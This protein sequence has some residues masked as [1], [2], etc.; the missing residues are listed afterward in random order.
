MS[1]PRQMTDAE[2]EWA[3]RALCA[4]RGINPDMEVPFSDLAGAFS[5]TYIRAWALALQEIN[6]QE[7][8]EYAMAVGRSYRDVAEARAQAEVR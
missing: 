3:A 8:L 1:T 7:R 6:N 5:A 2:K 4:L